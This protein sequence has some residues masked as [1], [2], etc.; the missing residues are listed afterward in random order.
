VKY[1]VRI[2]DNVSVRGCQG[3]RQHSGGGQLVPGEL[4]LLTPSR[5][6]SFEQCAS[7]GIVAAWPGWA[8]AGLRHHGKEA[9]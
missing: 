9:A 6:P 5:Q 7:R 3:S 2:V 4:R 8:A 1:V